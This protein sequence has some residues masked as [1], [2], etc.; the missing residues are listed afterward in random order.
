MVDTVGAGDLFTS[1][2]L[3]ALLKGAS[4]QASPCCLA[5]G[6]L[7]SRAAK[8]ALPPAF[9]ARQACCLC[10]N[11]LCRHAPRAVAPLARQQSRRQ[12][13]SSSQMRCSNYVQASPIF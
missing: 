12:E 7:L 8:R 6:G 10:P 4:L 2:F 9:E 13:P 5:A 1:G 3:F 11:H